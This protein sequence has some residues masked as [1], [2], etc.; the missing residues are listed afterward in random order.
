MTKSVGVQIRK[1][2]RQACPDR[3]VEHKHRLG[4]AQRKRHAHFLIIGLLLRRIYR[5]D[6]HVKQGGTRSQCLQ[7]GSQLLHVRHVFRKVGVVAAKRIYAEIEYN[8]DLLP[9]LVL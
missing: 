8:G 3:S 1:L 5:I 2:R 9:A 7:L 6:R 4:A